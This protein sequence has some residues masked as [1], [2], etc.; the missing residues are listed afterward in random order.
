MPSLTGS[1]HR[2][3]LHPVDA[4]ILDLFSVFFSDFFVRRDDDLAG[5]RML[6]V[7]QCNAAQDAVGHVLDDFTAFFERGHFHAVE[8]PQSVSMTIASCAIY[9]TSGHNRIGCFQGRIK[10]PCAPWVDS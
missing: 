3:D 5:K 1:E 4:S 7:F 8:G 6:D 10:A 9:K 2:A